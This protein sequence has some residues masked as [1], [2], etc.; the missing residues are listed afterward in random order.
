MK[1]LL[2]FFICIICSCQAKTSTK[3]NTSPSSITAKNSGAD[4][5][6]LDHLLKKY[7]DRTLVGLFLVDSVYTKKFSPVLNLKTSSYCSIDGFFRKNTSVTDSLSVLAEEYM[8]TIEDKRRNEILR[9]LEYWLKNDALLT[10]VINNLNKDLIFEEIISD[11]PETNVLL[12]QY[13][14]DPRQ[15][16]GSLDASQSCQLYYDVASYLLTLN[17]EKRIMFFK[18]YFDVACKISL[19]N[20]RVEK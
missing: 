5:H 8:E 16:W 7:Q 17:D 20:S 10:S 15:Y 9:Q 19:K 2:L 1:Y 11:L 4:S 18:Q 3:S 6:Y 12:K 13:L 14:K